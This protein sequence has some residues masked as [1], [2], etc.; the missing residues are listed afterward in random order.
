MKRK[1]KAD[2]VM[3]LNLLLK[4]GRFNKLVL[5]NRPLMR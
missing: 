4:E 2:F 5:V 1:R 3:N